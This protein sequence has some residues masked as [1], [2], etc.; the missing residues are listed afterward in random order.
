MTKSIQAVDNAGK[1]SEELLESHGLS[2]QERTSTPVRRDTL[3]KDKP[4]GFTLY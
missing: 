1:Y 3:E 4:N 2:H